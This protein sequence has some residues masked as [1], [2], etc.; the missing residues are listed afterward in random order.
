M[1]L[2]FLFKNLDFFRLNRKTNRAPET[3]DQL[4]RTIFVGN[5]PVS[6]TRK[7]IKQLFSKFGE[8]DSVWQRSLLHKTEKLTLKMLGTDK[9]LMANLK[10]TT[11]YVR[12]K[13]DEVVKK[14]IKMWVFFQKLVAYAT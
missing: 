12:L 4:A 7:Q 10:S 5:A 6:A 13:E 11:F 8:I 14:A 9:D 2:C 1:I 3:E